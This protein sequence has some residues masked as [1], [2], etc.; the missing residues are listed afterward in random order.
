MSIEA[1][2]WNAVGLPALAVPMGFDSDDL[3]LSLQIIGAHGA[4]A[5]VLAVGHHYQQLSDWHTREAPLFGAG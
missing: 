5:M 4:D 2:V 1:P 3:P